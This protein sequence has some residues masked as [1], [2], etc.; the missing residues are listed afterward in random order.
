MTE[1]LYLED[2][3]LQEFMAEVIE[4]DE[5]QKAVVLSA[6][7]F[8]PAGGGQ[9]CDFGI[10]HYQDKTVEVI[11]VKKEGGKVWHFIN[12]E[13]PDVGEKLTGKIDW[14]RRYKLMR[15]HTAMHAMSAIAWRDY[16]AQVTGGNMEPLAG[17]LDFE[18]E[19][20]NAE[21]VA[22]IEEKVNF[23]IKKGLAVSSQILPR[24]EAEKIPDLIR[25][26][27][28][29]LPAALTEIRVVTIADLD[30]QADGGTHVKS[31]S[32]IGTIKISGYKSKGRI[33]KRIKIAIL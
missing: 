28:N 9:P 18:F 31:T 1:L 24:S 17:R 6:T 2:S 7:A 5:E 29:L 25:T 16:Q 15:T 21:L 20:F 4:V 8:Y 14:E 33:N 19:N 27:I 12:G 22:E 10:L 11:K 3:Y 13:L 32:E 26:K 23:E 30:Q